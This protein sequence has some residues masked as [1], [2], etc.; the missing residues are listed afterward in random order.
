MEKRNQKLIAASQKL[1]NAQFAKQYLTSLWLLLYVTVSEYDFQ[2]YRN[3]KFNYF[4]KNQTKF[5]GRGTEPTLSV[6]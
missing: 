6:Q 3:V 2:I 1:R 5:T 4:A